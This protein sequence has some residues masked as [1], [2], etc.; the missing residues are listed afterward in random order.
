MTMLAGRYVETGVLIAFLL[1]IG[2]CTRIDPA[3]AQAEDEQRTASDVG[4]VVDKAPGERVA[5][6]LATDS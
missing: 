3:L 2:F 5:G 6:T 1:L 4:K